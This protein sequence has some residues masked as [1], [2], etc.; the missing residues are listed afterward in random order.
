MIMKHREKI[1]Y[2]LNHL[3]FGYLLRSPITGIIANSRA[4]A[5]TERWNF[6]RCPLMMEFFFFNLITWPNGFAEVIVILFVILRTMFGTLLS[7][8][9]IFP[10]VNQFWYRS[11]PI[12][13][14][15][16]FLMKRKFIDFQR[17]LLRLQSLK[18]QRKTNKI[19]SANSHVSC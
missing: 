16:Q 10:N 3:N 19:L 18:M 17:P 1:E 11:Q 4:V 14:T 13:W 8:N 7:P 12:R 6:T 15:S 5:R 2:T 9:H